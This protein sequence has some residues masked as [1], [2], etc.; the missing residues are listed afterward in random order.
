M[1]KRIVC[2]CILALMLLPGCWDKIELEEK[3]YVAVIG[4]D[5]GNIG[6]LSVTFQIQNP[7]VGSSERA[8]A[9]NEPPS[10]IITIEAVDVLSAK[11]TASAT[12]ARRLDFSHANAL[13]LSEEFARSSECYNYIGEL[14]RDREIRGEINVIISRE[15]ASEFIRNN[16]PPMETRPMKFY[17]LISKRWSESGITPAATLHTFLQR[18]EQDQ[19]LFLAIYGTTRRDVE[20]KFGLEDE[21]LAGEINMKSENPVQLIGSAVF[22][23]GR[24]IGTLNGEETRIVMLLRESKGFNGIISV[25]EDPIKSGEKIIA[26]LSTPKPPKIEVDLKKNKPEIQET[27]FG[28]YNI[29]SIPSHIDYVENIKNQELLKKSIERMV[30]EKTQKLID[31]TQREFSGEPFL[32][33]EAVSKEFLKYSD[34]VKYNWMDKYEDAEVKIQYEVK[35]KAFGKELNP[36]NIKKIRE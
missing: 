14:L 4:I 24:M 5:K 28:E 26:K 10:E 13:I 7:Q 21:Y 19:S 2:M 36:S 33:G 25:L 30:E 12:V 31:K 1:K 16:I 11:D 3:G 20:K 29:I 23:E 18:T 9:E 34:F 32:W 22:K 8:K 6:D 27:I 15:N 17:E 35:L